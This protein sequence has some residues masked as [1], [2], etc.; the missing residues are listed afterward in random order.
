MYP[1]EGISLVLKM[2]LC[3]SDTSIM[4][5]MKFLLVLNILQ[6]LQANHPDIGMR[7]SYNFC[8]A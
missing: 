7:T 5:C 2:L 3:L 8:Y 4:S 1:S 6:L